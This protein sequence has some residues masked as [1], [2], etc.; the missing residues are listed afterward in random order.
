MCWTWTFVFLV[1]KWCS[2]C[3]FIWLCGKF[4]FLCYTILTSLFACSLP[5]MLIWAFI[6]YIVVGCV[7]FWSMST[8][9]SNMVLSVWFRCSMGCLSYVLSTYRQLR[10]FVNICVGSC[11]YLF[12]IIHRVLCMAISSAL[13]LVCNPGSRSEIWIYVLW[14]GCICRIPLFYVS[15]GHLNVVLVVYPVA[16]QMLFSS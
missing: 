13:K 9:D 7:R 8:I 6:L 5:K 11:R 12:V 16:I 3:K 1:I 10:Q 2:V 15:S 14:K 4:V